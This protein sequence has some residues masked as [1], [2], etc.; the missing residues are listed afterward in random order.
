MTT[1]L[2]TPP[3]IS[4]EQAQPTV[5]PSQVNE[6]T[7]SM[8]AFGELLGSTAASWARCR[9]CSRRSG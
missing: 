1:A 9:S 3:E 2:L 6:A 7:V 5:F 8:A 4:V